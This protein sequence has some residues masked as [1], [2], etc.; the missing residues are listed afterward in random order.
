MESSFDFSS[1]IKTLPAQPGVYRMLDGQE[2]VIYVG[3]ARDLKR[4]VSSYFQKQHDNPRTRLMV[5]QVARIEVTLTASEAEALLLESNLIKELQ[6]RFNVLFKDD[7]SYPYILL[8]AHPFPQIRLYRGVLD[9]RHRYF[10]PYPN[11]WAARE[12]IGHLQKL[13]QLRTCADTVFKNRS[14]ACLLHQ[15]GRCK[16]PC[17]NL[18]SASEYAQDV[19]QAMAFLQGRE[20]EILDTLRASMQQ[21]AQEQAFERAAQ[22]RDRIALMQQVLSHQSV[23][24]TRE[25]D[26]D[27]I[28]T[29]VGAQRV[30]LN[31]V[32][33]RAGRHLGDKS[34]FPQNAQA[35]D[36]STVIEAFMTQHYS[37][38]EVPGVIVATALQD[39]E[40]LAQL[41]S[42]RHGRPVHIITHPQGEKR[43]W[44]QGAWQNARFAVEQRQAQQAVQGLRLDSLQQSL[45]LATLPARIECF[46]ISHLQGEATVASCVVFEEGKPFKTD[47]RRYNIEGITPGDD[48]AAMRQVL[49][50]RYQPLVHGEGKRPDLILIDGGRGQLNA[51]W[52][53]LQDLGLNDLTLVGV[54][55]GEGRKPGLE[56]LVFPQN[57]RSLSLPGDDPGLHLIQAVRDEAHRF[58]ITGHR[59][60]RGKSRLQSTLQEIE[61]I[62][63]KR[64]QK[65]LLQFGGLKGVQNASVEDIAAIP[66]IGLVLAQKIWHQLH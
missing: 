14:R 56:T 42:Q 32:M 55:K 6:P 13:F 37:D 2:D 26:V 16:A 38:Y 44:Y 15:I 57:Q 63:A 35:V 29:H 20:S 30:A 60:R 66:G 1:F 50:R 48:Y 39:P 24:S 12:V 47:Y 17:V 54:A 46:D 5:S 19:Q 11:A 7:K 49:L 40:G 31:L 45:E 28:A 36:E 41:L 59:A 9:A 25:S 33:I 34:F 10:G 65:L 4:R 62:G 58:A 22:I 27:I 8:T 21:A 18:V 61:G 43:A 64:R 52:M 53:V 3:K 23:S 51:A